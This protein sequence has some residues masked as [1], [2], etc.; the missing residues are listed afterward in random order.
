[1]PMISRCSRASWLALV[2]ATVS[3]ADR[4]AHACGPYLAT[5]MLQR[6]HEA[7]CQTPSLQF[8]SV[9]AQRTPSSTL[10]AVATPTDEA[11]Q[12]DLRIAWLDAGLDAEE[13]DA[14]L[15]MIAAYREQFEDYGRRDQ[16]PLPLPELPAEFRHY[17]LGARA[18]H[19]Y[20]Y[21]D[22]ERH[23]QAVLELP[24][25]ERRFRSTWAAYML[26][27][28]GAGIGERCPESDRASA[29]VRELAA[30]GF[31]DSLGLAAASYGQQAQ[32]WYHAGDLVRAIELYLQQLA[33][34]DETA[35]NSIALTLQVQF[36][37]GVAGGR[38]SLYDFARHPQIRELVGLWLIGD[39]QADLEWSK[40]W[41]IALERTRLEHAVEAGPL[42]WA[43]YQSGD[44]DTAARWARLG[45]RSFEHGDPLARWVLAKLELREGDIEA[46]A[47]ALARIE[48]ELDRGSYEDL[49]LVEWRYGNWTFDEK[50]AGASAAAELGVVELARDRFIPALDAFVRAGSYVDAAYVAEQLLTIEELVTWIDDHDTNPTGAPAVDFEFDQRL[51]WLL[52]RRLARA[53][54]WHRA[55]PY[56]PDAW[57]AKAEAHAADLDAL[58]NTALPN[59]ERARLL[60][61]VA[62]RTR[63]HGMELRGTELDPDWTLHEGTYSQGSIWS[64]REDDHSP[65]GPS[66]AERARHY[67]N[68]FGDEQVVGRFH[69]RWVAADYAWQAAELLP[70]QH[71]ATARVL[72]IA[73]TWIADRDPVE[74]N[75]FYQAMVNRNRAVDVAQWADAA[76]WFPDVEQCSLRGIDFAQPSVRVPIRPP[77]ERKNSRRELAR[78]AWPVA[79]LFGLF[80]LVGFLLI[81]TRPKDRPRA[82]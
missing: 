47:A 20:E 57:R 16:P 72:C 60:W 55:L 19:R 41:L 22:A 35:E 5:A 3:L 8:A 12:A 14:R 6:D 81:P 9:L 79:A 30:D 64:I 66:E 29:R 24:S 63:E 43:A 78:R 42:A 53:G 68:R 26:A 49:R 65:T 4:P 54:Q 77:P 75:R 46:A 18:W 50:Q 67:A 1:M 23:F 32:C 13:L 73:G 59:V 56:Y 25:T 44:M 31:H 52:A 74:A 36:M 48:V 71:P 37:G 61:R 70:D 40:M 2:L 45:A 58:E 69:Y 33:T 82:P 80:A 76:R 10:Q 11:E 39:N 38:T 27:R 17:L 21:D 7:L 15:T 62:Q 28:G 34:G 51:R